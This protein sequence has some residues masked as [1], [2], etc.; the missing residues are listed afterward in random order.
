ML[1][2]EHKIINALGGKAFRRNMVVQLLL[3]D[4][5]F[6]TPYGRVNRVLSPT[7]VEVFYQRSRKILH[8]D[9]LEITKYKGYSYNR[10]YD[11]R[12]Q[13]MWMPTLRA[14]YFDKKVWKKNR[15]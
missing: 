4:D 12:P 5:G 8:P 2:R 11:G 13:F 14:S 10:L 15:K 7:E 1:P 6:W 3:D 9:Q